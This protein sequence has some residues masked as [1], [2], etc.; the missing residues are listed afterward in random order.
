MEPCATKPIGLLTG[1]AKAAVNACLHPPSMKCR[2][3]GESTR[4]ELHETFGSVEGVRRQTDEE[5]LKVVTQVQLRD[6]RRPLGKASIASIGGKAGSRNNFFVMII[7]ALLAL[8]TILFP[9]QSFLPPTQC[10]F[11]FTPFLLY[12][13]HLFFPNSH[14][15]KLSLLLGSIG[16]AMAGYVLPTKSFAQN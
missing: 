10:H 11:P 3:V 7:A 6:K 4:I 15:E 14:Y 1:S 12:F 13:S 8:P 2:G 5:L 9:S 16:G